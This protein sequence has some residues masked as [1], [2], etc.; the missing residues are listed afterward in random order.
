MHAPHAIVA[1]ASLYAQNYD[2]PSARTNFPWFWVV[3]LVIVVAA[4]VWY[5]SARSGG[6]RNVPP[7]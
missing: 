5:V 1:A 4:L 3:M 7:P 2:G 6:G